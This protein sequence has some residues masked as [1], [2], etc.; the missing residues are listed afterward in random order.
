[1]WLV[2]LILF[3]LQGMTKI[4]LYDLS[5]TDQYN[6]YL[7]NI[8]FY[9]RDFN[10]ICLHFLLSHVGIQQYTNNIET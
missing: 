4:G 9:I 8:L 10:K 7:P 3:Q 1:M 5:L 6:S 2:I